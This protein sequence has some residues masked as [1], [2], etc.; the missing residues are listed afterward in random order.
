MHVTHLDSFHAISATTLPHFSFLPLL[1]IC[2]K[3]AENDLLPEWQEGSGF[4][5]PETFS[6]HLMLSGIFTAFHRNHPSSWSWREVTLV[7]DHWPPFLYLHISSRFPYY[8]N[9]LIACLGCWEISLC[10]IIISRFLWLLLK[11]CSPM[12]KLNLWYIKRRF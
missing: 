5:I 2:Q 7:P 1:Y 8:E 4:Q 3:N 9:P 10:H 12:L 11:M 6:S